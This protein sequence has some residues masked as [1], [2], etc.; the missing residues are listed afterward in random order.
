VTLLT[1]IR[2]RW[3]ALALLLGSSLQ[4]QVGGVLQ[5][6]DDLRAALVLGFARFTEW[7]A[8]QREGPLVIGVLGHPGIV[9]SMEK[10]AAGK[11]VNGRPVIV[12]PLRSGVQAAGCHIVYFGRLTGMR[13]ADLLKEMLTAEA[14]PSRLLIGEDDR[15]LAAG[16]AVH[17]FEEDGRVSFDANLDALQQANLTISSKLLRLGYTS[18]DNKRGRTKP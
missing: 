12:R 5:Q 8:A 9:A 13:L 10:V 17:L 11:V 7:P 2:L 1:P 16:G 18:R 14:R 15:F 3:L 6:E 4:A